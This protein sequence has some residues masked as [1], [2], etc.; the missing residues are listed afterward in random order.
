MPAEIV[1]LYKR[2]V[3][4]DPTDRPSAGD[5]HAVLAAVADL[6]LDAARQNFA[7]ADSGTADA[8]APLPRAVDV[9]RPRP[10]ERTAALNATR[11]QL[12][13]PRARSV[14]V[15]GRRNSGARR[16]LAF[17]TT[18][19][20]VLAGV[21]LLVGRPSHGLPTVAIPGPSVSRTL[22]IRT[23]TPRP[24][25]SNGPARTPAPVPVG[26]E[27]TQELAGNVATPT[28]TPDK[29]ARPDST[30]T[31]APS[32]STSAGQTF[33]SSGGSVVAACDGRQA[34]LTSWEP[35]PSYEVGDINAG[36]AAKARATF[37]SGSTMVVMTVTC[38]H[39]TPDVSVKTT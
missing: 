12:T 32:A 4:K 15:P 22:D 17:L 5:A 27:G 19:A 29:T 7:P 25:N 11:A 37:V 33:T 2:C 24:L 23:P 36:P 14:A 3:A 16:T 1:A 34:Y 18:A 8:I 6:P 39:S 31:P 10:H 35:A 21:W 26:P 9:E 20:A 30:G 38:P 28:D 13:M